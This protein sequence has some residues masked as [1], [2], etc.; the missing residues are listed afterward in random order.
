M[1]GFDVSLRNLVKSARQISRFLLY[2]GLNQVLMSVNWLLDYS[3][4]INC[5]SNKICGVDNAPYM[6]FLP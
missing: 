4:V 6:E 5:L 1:D 2:R 3:F